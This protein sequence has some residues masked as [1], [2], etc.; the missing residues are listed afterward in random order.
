MNGEEWGECNGKDEEREEGEVDEG[1]DGCNGKE[2]RRRRGGRG[3][4]IM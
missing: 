2:D 1:K 3:H 4:Y